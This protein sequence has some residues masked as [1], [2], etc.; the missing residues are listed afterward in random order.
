VPRV[1][2]GFEL[3][4][5]SID[6]T[7]PLGRGSAV[8]AYAK[9]HTGPYFYL[10]LP[11]EADAIYLPTDNPDTELCVWY[12][13]WDG[14]FPDGRSVDYEESDPPPVIRE[15]GNLRGELVIDNVEDI[16]ITTLQRATSPDTGNGHR[17]QED[18]ARYSELAHRIRDTMFDPLSTFVDLLRHRFGQYWVLPLPRTLRVYSDPSKFFELFISFTWS[19]DEFETEFDFDPP[20]LARPATIPESLRH[21][22]HE[23]LTEG[24]WN[25][26]REM[27]SSRLVS[28]NPMPGLGHEMFS[29]ARQARDRGEMRS[30]Y[31]E[32]VTALEV[33]VESRRT[34][35]REFDSYAV[36]GRP[37]L[38]VEVERSFPQLFS[39]FPRRAEEAIQTRNKIVHEGSPVTPGYVAEIDSLLDVVW[40]LLDPSPKRPSA[41]ITAFRDSAYL[42]PDHKDV[43]HVCPSCGYHWHYR[44]QG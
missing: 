27:A 8:E 30:A 39:S 6:L 19:V 29:R 31:V 4:I 9:Y 40:R 12:E 22:V 23:L 35:V 7:P 32:A 38:A 18:I 44:T 14:E 5:P 42:D 1:D 3:E 13:G 34:D 15:G 10:W 33:I 17:S 36:H 43:E 24:D 16:V 26:L 37:R 25:S 20:S 28:E 2:F 41:A 21:E 11:D